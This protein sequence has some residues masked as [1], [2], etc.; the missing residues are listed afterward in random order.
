MTHFLH[1]NVQHYELK[2]EL[3]VPNWRTGTIDCTCYVIGLQ[4]L[5]LKKSILSWLYLTTYLYTNTLYFIKHLILWS[6]PSETIT[7]IKWHNYDIRTAQ[8][9]PL[10]LHPWGWSCAFNA[11]P[12]GNR[13][14]KLWSWC[15]ALLIKQICTTMQMVKHAQKSFF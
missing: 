12:F 14:Q 10:P 4:F 15:Q 2:S 7:N 5:V 13:A 3:S 1:S 6:I 11:Y 8:E 9:S